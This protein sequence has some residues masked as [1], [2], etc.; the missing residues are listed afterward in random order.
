[1]S[2]IPNALHTNPNSD[3]EEASKNILPK[4][5]GTKVVLDKDNKTD[6]INDFMICVAV[7]VVVFT[8][9]CDCNAYFCLD[10]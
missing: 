1:M 8:V 2:H 10:T 4:A 9:V 6:V 5:E 7:L 3:G